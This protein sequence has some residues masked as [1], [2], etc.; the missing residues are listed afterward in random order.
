M[1][2]IINY[3]ILVILYNIINILM[4]TE[5]DSSIR[6]FIDLSES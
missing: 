5:Y 4:D 1:Y 6:F 2:I 3:L